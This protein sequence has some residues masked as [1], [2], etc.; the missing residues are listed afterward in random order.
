MVSFKRA[1]N[2]DRVKAIEIIDKTLMEFGLDNSCTKHHSDLND[3]EQSY[4]NGYF[5]FILLNGKIVGTL[6]LYP[7]SYDEA[8]IRKMY[9]VPEARGHGAGKLALEFLLNEAKHLDYKTVSLET[10]TKFKAAI[11]LYTKYGFREYFKDGQ[12]AGCDRRFV[13]ERG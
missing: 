12:T 7:L 3:L 6:G 1:T 9:L 8:E 10:S 4:E 2:T 11:G 5:G 13:L